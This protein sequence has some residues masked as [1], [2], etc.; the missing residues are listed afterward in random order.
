MQ[1]RHVVMTNY[2]VLKEA[3]DKENYH[4]ITWPGFGGADAVIMFNQ[5]YQKDPLAGQTDAESRLPHR[6]VPRDQS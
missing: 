6:P 3:E 4:I 5:T 2:P 1:D